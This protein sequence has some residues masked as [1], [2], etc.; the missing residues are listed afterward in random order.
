MT[1]LL[2]K[3]ITDHQWTVNFVQDELMINRKQL[4][5][6]KQKPF[7]DHLEIQR[8]EYEIGLFEQGIDQHQ[9]IIK[10]LQQDAQ[11]QD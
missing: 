2:Q 4:A 10:K 11:S 8:L 3:K 1:F 7:P 9:D 6:E 5:Q